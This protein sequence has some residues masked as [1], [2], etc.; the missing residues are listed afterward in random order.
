MEY[1]PIAR[2]IWY[3][4]RL[5]SREQAP[6]RLLRVDPQLADLIPVFRDDGAGLSLADLQAQPGLVAAINANFFNETAILGDLQDGPRRRL[7]D[8]DTAFDA[9]SD[10]WTHLAIGL[11]GRLEIA[12]G[13]LPEN[14]RAARLRSFIGGFPQL[15]SPAQGPTLEADIASGALP[16]RLP[17]HGA[18]LTS[19]ISR[20]FLGIRADGQVLLMVA[21]EGAQRSQGASFVE[22]ARLL[23][24]L[25]AVEAYILDG[26]GSSCLYLQ[27][28]WAARAPA[29]RRMKVFI[30]A[31]ER[32]VWRTG[33]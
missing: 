24:A 30:G 22:G 7:D 23:K 28:R 5:R 32:G 20:N 16:R 26:G 19:S 4:D 27:G 18:N 29:K 10:F 33:G 13:G 31:R 2:G 14:A 15:F 12:R 6:I 8:T 1:L 17:F 3:S 9:R 11:D 25:G 21:G